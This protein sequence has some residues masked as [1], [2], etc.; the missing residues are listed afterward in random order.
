M[1]IPPELVEAKAAVKLGL[2][3]LPG[4]VGVGLGVREANE[5]FFDE[6]AVRILVEDAGQV[7]ADVPPRSSVSCRDLRRRRS[8]QCARAWRIILAHQFGSGPDPRNSNCAFESPIGSPSGS[9]SRPDRRLQARGVV[10]DA[11]F[12]PS[13]HIKSFTTARHLHTES[14][15]MVQSSSGLTNF[16]SD[17]R[18]E[19]LQRKAVTFLA[20]KAVADLVAA[21]VLVFPCRTRAG[22]VNV[23]E[24]LVLSAVAIQRLVDR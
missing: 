3:S 4:V 17:Y 8:E 23:V 15:A 14:I 10:Y 11:R 18:S 2:L 22:C 20:G 13:R 9:T 5:E 1:D 7:P 24:L 16:D 21:N 6:L 19:G 12:M